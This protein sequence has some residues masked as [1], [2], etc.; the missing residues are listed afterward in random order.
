LSASDP[1]KE[2]HHDEFDDEDPNDVSAEDLEDAIA[3]F[4]QEAGM[5]PTQNATIGQHKDPAPS[6]KQSTI[7]GSSP[8]DSQMTPIAKKQDHTDPAALSEDEY[9]GD[10]EFEDIVAECEKATQGQPSTS[11]LCTNVCV[12]R[13]GS[14]T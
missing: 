4:D 11:Q 12:R 8:E 14:S 7:Y 5:R 10:L 6:Q 13:F 1:P 3:M 9:G 2:L